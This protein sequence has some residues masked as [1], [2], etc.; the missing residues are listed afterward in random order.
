MFK[1]RVFEELLEAMASDAMSP[2]SGAAAAS[3]LALGIA[4]LRKAVAVSAK[5]D[6]D[7]ADLHEAAARLCG[8]SERAFAAADADVI[9]FPRLASGQR[10]KEE[11]AESADDLAALGERVSELCAQLVSEADMIA[12]HIRPA[13]ANDLLAAWRLGEAAAAIAQANGAENAAQVAN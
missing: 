9:G 4:C 3:A 1:H 7:N 13:M 10:S 5:H 6:P 11:R 12:P 8:L 2:G